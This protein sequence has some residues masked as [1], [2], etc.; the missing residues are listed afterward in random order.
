MRPESPTTRVLNCH[1][2]RAAALAVFALLSLPA[3]LWA[4]ASPS[5]K[6]TPAVHLIV[7][8]VPPLIYQQGEALTFVGRIE[9]TSGEARTVGIVYLTYEAAGKR[10]V[11]LERSLQVPA[12]EQRRIE[13][14]FASGTWRRAEVGISSGDDVAQVVR[15]QAVN[16]RDKLPAGLRAVGM[17][18]RV[19]ED[20]AV[21]RVPKRT[22]EVHHW[23]LPRAIYR[24]FTRGDLPDSIL[25]L[26]H[27]LAAA[28]A[29]T[30]RRQPVSRRAAE[31]APDVSGPGPSLGIGGGPL[32][33]AA[34]D[35]AVKFQIKPVALENDETTY[36]VL[37]LL[38]A[39][40]AQI[41]A[42]GKAKDAPDAAVVLLGPDD[43]RL[44]T[45]RR[46]YQM[47]VEALLDRLRRQRIGRVLIVGPMT[48][49]VPAKQLK[50]YIESARR[51]THTRKAR[52]L[53]LSTVLGPKHWHVAGGKGVLGRYPN[54]AGLAVAA[55]S[56]LKELR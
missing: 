34:R 31:K 20:Y 14:T 9:N 42:W 55:V 53:D 16:P 24:Q 32:R 22:G 46:L 1:V 33:Q 45:P 12:Q 17:T 15:I 37:K 27:P 3:P 2:H 50:T 48:Y 28:T 40:A 18:L 44:A 52:F 51:A 56:I 41:S 13:H 36:P 43:P 35:E 39:L 26:G 4:S 11:R 30:E 8:Y 23:K 21:L 5:A 10:P 25:V 29:E 7:D 19:G 49:G 6:T 38:P 47:A 54:A